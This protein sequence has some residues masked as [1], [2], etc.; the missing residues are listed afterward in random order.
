MPL[1]KVKSSSNMYKFI[2][3]TWNTV[4]GECPHNCAYCYMKRWGE[5]KPVRFDE[6][7]LKTDLGTGNFI[8]VG[9]SCDMFAEKIPSKWIYKTLDHSCIYNNIYLFQSKNPR[10]FCDMQIY[11]PENV[12]LGTTIESNLRYKEMGDAPSAAYRVAALQYLQA[13]GFKTMITI[14]PVMDFDIEDMVFLIKKCQPSWVNIGANTN[15]KIKLPEPS[16]EKITKLI[17]KLRDITKVKNKPNLQ[18]LRS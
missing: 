9:S 17:E 15:T 11:F 10:R 1:N 2:D 7:E 18:R 3:A 6:K 8:F 4:K 14:E 12:I 16:P 13:N 5:Q